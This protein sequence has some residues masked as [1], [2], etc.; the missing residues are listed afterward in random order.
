MT[1]GQLVKLIIIAYKDIDYSKATGDEYSTLLNPQ[2]FSENYRVQYHAVQAAGTT[3]SDLKFQRIE[4]KILKLNFLFDATGVVKVAA[5]HGVKSVAEQ[6]KDFKKVTVDYQGVTHS[7]PYVK[8]IWGE[9]LFKGILESLDIT[10][11][12]FKADGT[13]LR[14]KATTVFKRSVSDSTREKQENKSSPDLTHMRLVKAGD[15]L[16]A[17]AKEIYGD[18]SY[19]LK[20]AQD[21]KLKNFRRLEPGQKIFFKPLVSTC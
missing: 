20:L 18:A 11:T 2:E 19:Y 13:P 14:A 6:I 21:N 1:N 3:G 16:P 8:I 7:P 17:L 10:Y 12:L 9:L 4:P 15:T 5:S